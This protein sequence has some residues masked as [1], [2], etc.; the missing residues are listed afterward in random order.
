MEKQK[1]ISELQKLYESV[2]KNKQKFILNTLCNDVF[3]VFSNA[4]L[5]MIRKKK[6]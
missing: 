2:D 1:R 4:A 3:K 6:G 5:T